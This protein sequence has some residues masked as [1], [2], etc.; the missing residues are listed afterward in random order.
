MKA[1]TLVERNRFLCGLFA[2]GAVFVGSAG[3]LGS[4]VV[5]QVTPS[6]P[7][8][9]YWVEQSRQIGKGDI[10]VFEAPADARMLIAAR[11][12][13]KLSVGYLLMKPVVAR[14]GDRVRV[15]AKGL[16]INSVFFGAVER[17]DTE[18]LPLPLR[19]IDRVLSEHEYFTASRYEH[20][21]D[22]RYFG[23]IRREAIKGVARRVM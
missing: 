16:F 4:R 3:L 5:L 18:G 19:E 17:I 9:V 14:K 22:S 15:S 6:M 1:R 21:F 20:S 10:I 12:W 23:I 7:R 2:A 13:W 11:H 8:G